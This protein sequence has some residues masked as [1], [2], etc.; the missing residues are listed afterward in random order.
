MI[1]LLFL[2]LALPLSHTLA[3]ATA[4][5]TATTATAIDCKQGHFIMVFSARNN[6]GRRMAIRKTWADDYTYFFMGARR[7]P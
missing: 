5:A 1:A 7:G 6:Y 4:T 3:L 2:F